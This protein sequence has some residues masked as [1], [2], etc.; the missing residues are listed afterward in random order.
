MNDTLPKVS[1][2]I[3]AGGKSR[4]MGRDKALLEFDGKTLIER[5]IERVRTVSDDIII[6]CND[7]DT[8]AKFGVRI[9]TDVIP[10]KGS[11]GGLY[12]GM[13]AARE[14][15]ALALACDMPFLNDALLR[16]L[17]FLTPGFD[18]VIPQARGL[19]SVA[20]RSFGIAQP[21]QGTTPPLS[22]QPL[23]KEKDL[24]PMH[25]IY[26]RFADD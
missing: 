26:S 2:V 7:V 11:L 5:V 19:S 6:V 25:A 15:Y 10:G 9:V 18:V 23:A 8:Y 12:S 22:D 3:L 17:I 1:A 21:R 14:E 20:P 24:H 16:Y 4:R 13:L